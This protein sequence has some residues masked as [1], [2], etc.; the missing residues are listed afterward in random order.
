MFFILN[1]NSRED[2]KCED[3]LH[4]SFI[5]EL[6]EEMQFIDGFHVLLDIWCCNVKILTQHTKWKHKL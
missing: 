3:V 2:Y 6:W 1:M 4:S 5:L